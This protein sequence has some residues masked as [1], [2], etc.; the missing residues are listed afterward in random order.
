MRRVCCR[1][2]QLSIVSDMAKFKRCA[3]TVGDASK[4]KARKPSPGLEVVNDFDAVLPVDPL[5][6][7]FESPAPLTWDRANIE[8]MSL[9]LDEAPRSCAGGSGP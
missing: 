8:L 6:V 9:L 1:A 4:A 7:L 2:T 3:I 5:V